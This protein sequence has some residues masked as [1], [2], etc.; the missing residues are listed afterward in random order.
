MCWFIVPL[1]LGI[2][3]VIQ[4]NKAIRSGIVAEN[5]KTGK[6][7]GI[8]GIA[9]GAVSVVVIIFYIVFFIWLSY[10]SYW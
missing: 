6:I 9:L 4:A 5:T 8:I 3:A 7:M 10:Y 2:I 1:I